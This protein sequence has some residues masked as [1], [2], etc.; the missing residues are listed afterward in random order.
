MMKRLLTTMVVLLSMVGMASAFAELD[1]DPD[2]QDIN[3]GETGTYTLTLNTDYTGGAFLTFLSENSLIWADIDDSTPEGSIGSIVITSDGSGSQ[4]FTLYVQPQSGVTQGETSDVIVTFSQGGSP[5]I[6]RAV[7][8]ASTNPVPEIA[9]IG[10][11][12]AGLIGLVFL[13][14]KN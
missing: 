10:L 14:R 8:T 1:V 9:T 12:G 2:E 3:I 7:A 5:A 11:V 4:T 13:R 6:A